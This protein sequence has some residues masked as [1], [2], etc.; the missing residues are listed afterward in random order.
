MHY[1]II[2]PELK[3]DYS[4]YDAVQSPLTETR[5]NSEYEIV[6]VTQGRASCIIEGSEF[7]IGPRSLLM[8]RPMTYHSFTIDSTTPYERYVV[9]FSEGALPPDARRMLEHLMQCSESGNYFP[10]GTVTDRVISAFERF[11]VARELQTEEKNAYV[12]AILSELV[13]FISALRGEKILRNEHE[14]GARV[15]R[16][17]NENIDKD[18][19]LD[20]LSAR[21]FVSKYYL[22]RAFKKQNG[23]SI[24]NYVNHKRIM[25]AKQLIDLGETAS[26]AAYKVGFGDYSAFYRA[27]LKIVGRSPTKENRK[28]KV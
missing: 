21:F 8:F 20:K 14:I 17:L 23:I 16:Y 1:Q 18:L 24:H 27:Y 25:Y 3:V 15:I 28:E 5:C 7:S 9:D 12:R 6:C 22:C 19:S 11:E 2:S 13:I 26:G 10:E 4:V